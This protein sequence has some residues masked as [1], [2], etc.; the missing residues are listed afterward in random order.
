MNIGFLL[1]NS[2]AKETN[3]NMNLY[4]ANKEPCGRAAIAMLETQDAADK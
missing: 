3:Y 2:A 4:R 1:K